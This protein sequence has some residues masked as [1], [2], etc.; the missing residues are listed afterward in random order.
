MDRSRRDDLFKDKI[1]L[2]SYMIIN[3]YTNR[4]SAG[5]MMKIIKSLQFKSEI[6]TYLIIQ[7]NM[8]NLSYIY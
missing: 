6:I 4:K 1:M 7:I 2:I 8:R 5:N 3:V